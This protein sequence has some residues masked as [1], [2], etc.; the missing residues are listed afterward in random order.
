VNARAKTDF[1]VKTCACGRRMSIQGFAT[2][3]LCDC[4]KVFACNLAQN[5]KGS[6][7]ME[8]EESEVGNG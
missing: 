8:I 6:W 4:G 7:Y 1:Y 2:E 5:E 3:A